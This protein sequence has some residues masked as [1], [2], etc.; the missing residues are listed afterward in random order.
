M[1]ARAGETG[2]TSP[3][4]RGR[5]GHP[6]V[7]GRECFAAL[8]AAEAEQNPRDVLSRFPRTLVEVDDAGVAQDFDT[9]EEWQSFQK[10]KV[11]R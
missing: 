4:Y 10:A 1:A 2:W 6:V 9:P 8:R 5:R 11:G 7:I 3:V